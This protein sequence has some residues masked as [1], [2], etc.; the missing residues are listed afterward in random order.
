MERFLVAI[1]E[2]GSP[3]ERSP[4]NEKVKLV[5]GT[6]LDS[7]V[8]NYF[9]KNKRQF[10]EEF[11]EELAGKL[12]GADF[13]VFCEVVAQEWFDSK[14]LRQGG[15]CRSL[16]RSIYEYLSAITH[17][18]VTNAQ[19]VQVK[20]APLDVEP[21]ISVESVAKILTVN[22]QMLHRH[23]EEWKQLRP[24]SDEL[25]SGD[26]FLRRGVGLDGPLDVTKPYLEWDFIN[27]YS[28]ALS[29]PEKF[30]QMTRG[31]TPAI[32]N[33]DLGL[34]EGRVL[35]FSPFIPEMEV[36]QL[37]FGIIPAEKALP[38]YSQGEHGGILEYIIDP[39]P[40]QR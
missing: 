32:L 30:A 37:E 6:E 2:D 27:S 17:G 9:T 11:T 40:F 24:N 19:F 20:D 34:F 1:H 21:L 29:A 28:I 3:I 18:S 26:V 31:K 5:D 36:G 39:A 15:R 13:Q 12:E 8:L 38:L 35:F 16:M 14:R 4:N 22:D 10:R 7:D 23:I 25:S 33:A